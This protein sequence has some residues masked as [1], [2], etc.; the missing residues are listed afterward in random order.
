M[1]EKLIKMRQK[2]TVELVQREIAASGLVEKLEDQICF[3][4][5]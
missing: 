3:G 2:F 4:W 1:S 5:S